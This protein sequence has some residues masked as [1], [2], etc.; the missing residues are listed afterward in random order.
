MNIVCIGAHPDDSEYYAGG[1]LVKWARNGHRVLVVS[2][3]NG[4][5]GHFTMAGGVLA[6][7]RAAE[8][9]KSAERAGVSECVL[10][11]HDGELMPTLEVRKAVVKLI[12]EFEADIVL[13]HRP[14]DYHPDHRYCA[15]AVQDAAFMVTV[16]FF[17]PDIPA[18]KKNPVFLYMMDTFTKPAPLRPDIAV[19]VDDVMD[20]K[21]SLLDAMES[22][23]YEWLPWLEGRLGEVPADPVQRRVWLEKTFSPYFKGFA[24]GARKALEKYYGAAAA[25][26]VVHAE[27]FEICEYG[28]QPSSKEILDLFPFLPRLKP[29]RGE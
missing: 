10:D 8:A 15:M 5:I 16:P 25:K 14:W 18:L 21:W 23:F 19:A 2:L 4:D 29:K 1:T 3:T 27:L 11:F 12:R 20:V 26:G 9:R 7:R 13:T 17:C 6:R 24:R 28:R 22:Q